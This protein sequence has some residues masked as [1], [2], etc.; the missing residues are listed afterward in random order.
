MP[1]ECQNSVTLK[2]FLLPPLEKQIMCQFLASITIGSL[3]AEKLIRL[4]VGCLTEWAIVIF[5]KS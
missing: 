5:L 4:V 3:V 2:T 1:T